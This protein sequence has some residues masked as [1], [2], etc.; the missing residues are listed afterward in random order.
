LTAARQNIISTFRINRKKFNE[1]EFQQMKLTDYVANFL[2][3]E[4]VKCVFGLTGGAAVHLFDSIDKNPSI[5]PIFNHHE[6]ASALAAEAYSKITNNLGTAFVTT[7]PGG[8]NAV[9]G[10]TAAWL[11][12]IPCIY[13][14]GQSRI[15]H[16]TRNKPIRQLGSQELDIISIVEPVTKYAVLLD[17]PKKIKY[18][19][20]KAA[21]IAKTGRP[22]PVWV[23]VP[24]NFQWLDID[25]DELPGFDPKEVEE[26][27]T[28][29]SDLQVSV[30]K[31]LDML[32]SAKRPIV[33][34]GYG[35]RLAHA[36]KEFKQFIET[37]KIPF[38]SSWTASDILPT[39][40]KLYMG[41][42]GIAGQR[43]ANLAVQ[44]CD[45]LICIGSHLSLPLTGTNFKAF[46]REAR[47]IVVDIDPVELGFETVKV[48]LP[49]Q[50]DARRFLKEMLESKSATEDG[51]LK[52][53][54]DKCSKYKGY[55]EIPDEWRKQKRYVNPYVFIDLLS[56]ELGKN[57]VIVVDGGGTVV[58]IS[59]QAFKVKEGQRLIESSGIGAMGTGLP[60]AI[61]ACFANGKKRTICLCGDGSMQF[62]IQELQAIVHL[63]V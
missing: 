50:C 5:E 14:S 36:E 31:C 6:Q 19:L 54:H 55:N 37:L 48:D 21:Y 7:G 25:P 1:G 10:V 35:I 62:N 59:F 53:W 27:R 34:A 61:G 18:C 8:T 17:D 13:I 51:G 57:D 41:R 63:C 43:G 4:G 46:A 12:S 30:K 16:T 39:D 3:K 23:D 32:C 38:V 11:D 24:L 22:G 28:S 40:H 56:D 52:W 15:E 2:E 47:K 9:T 33:L 20:Q 26:K 42:S 44:N 29:D 58:Y 60:E 49:V 45:L